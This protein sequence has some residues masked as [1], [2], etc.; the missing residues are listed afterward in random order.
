MAAAV[1][2]PAI[3]EAIDKFT[4]P[5]RR[6]MGSTTQ[7]AAAVETSAARANRAFT[8]MAAP[9]TRITTMLGKMGMLLGAAAVF[10][11]VVSMV[12]II[13]D[14]EQANAN[15]A[16]VMATATR[17]EL[18][19]LQKDAERLGAITAK[20][21]TEV[22]GLQEAYARLGFT[23]P[24]ILNMTEATIAGSVGMNSELAATAELVGAMVRTFDDF[25]SVDAPLVM[26]QIVK[27]TQ[28]SA[29]SF[30][31][32]ATALPIVGGA[33]NAAGIPF[34]KVLSL[35]GKLSDAGID[36][37]TSATSLRNLF[38]EAAASGKPYSQILDE[39]EKSTNKL[40]SADETLGKRGAVQSVVLAGQAMGLD[41][42]DKAL[43]NAAGTAETAAKTQLNTLNGSLTLLTS[44][45]EGFVLSLD[46]GTGK[47]SKTLRF[48]VD[49]TAD[50]F[51]M[52]AG[53]SSATGAVHAFAIAGSVLLGVLAIYLTTLAALKIY[54]IGATLASWGLTVATTAQNLATK[55]GTL[56]QYQLAAAFF[57]NIARMRLVAIGTFLT[58]TATGALTGAVSL[59]TA[60]QWALNSAMLANPIG[61]IIIAIVALI[62][63]VAII[64]AKYDEWGA[65]LTF[66]LGPLGMVINLIM[67]FRRNWEMISDA[68]QNGGIIAG[69]KA[70]GATIL[71][72][73]L[74]PL[75]QVM[76][77][78]SNM[79]GFMGG[80]A[81][82]GAAASLDQFRSN[83]GVSTSEPAPAVNPKAAQQN[84]MR[85][86]L[87][88]TTNNNSNMVI[89]FKNMPKG[90]DVGGDYQDMMP[91]L[92]TT[93]GF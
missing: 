24:E 91:N 81:A 35:L 44:A 16:S 26:D 58:A 67:A 14:F 92:G 39:I 33:A 48:F 54:S 5:V 53:T 37:S 15:L 73:I 31:K 90:V 19:A 8:A 76:E 11:A 27:A 47:F 79:P 85:Q 36:A 84:G 23:A 34:T 51:S 29:L 52:A 61:L 64:V 72:A 3:F 7:F 66:L 25:S 77:I 13:K 10:G 41:I 17:P 68:F 57:I 40:A 32:L 71:D 6:M 55:L 30:D 21:A 59:A 22:V 56:A 86:M 82:A 83:L 42:L 18:Q 28:L 38:L 2:V 89:D 49:V 50:I 45:Y 65:S 9:I 46:N 75:Q 80:N 88:T 87:E 74:Y 43:Q 60:A 78:W 69:I 12:G 1:K 70:I 4:A 63:T 93:Y 62:A 20:T